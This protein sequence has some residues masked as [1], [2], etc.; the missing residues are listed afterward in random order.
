MSIDWIY[1]ALTATS[2]F[3]GF[4]DAVAGGGGLITV[5][6]LI[7]AGLPPAMVLGTNKAQSA[8]GTAMATWRYHRAG[9]FE[10]RPSLPGAAAVFLGAMIGTLVVSHLKAEWLRLI[11]P[12][13]LMAISLY[14]LLSP[15]M[16]DAD[17]HARVSP[18]GYLPAGTAVGFYDGFFGPGAGQFYTMSLVTLRGMGLTRATALTK[19]FNMTSNIASIIVFAAGG[20]IMWLLGG[21]MAAG[22]MS[23]AWIGSHMASRLG[24]KVIRPLLVVVSL[25]MTGKLVWGWFAG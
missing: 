19:L 11:V 21:C 1:P 23:G 18:R 3:A 7:Y 17:A 15:R 12:A 24:A 14:T 4:V 20:K 5:P 22:A 8:C 25:S 13:L 9:L 10:L 2:V 16:S 6:A